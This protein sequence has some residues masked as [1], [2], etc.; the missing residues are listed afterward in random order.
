MGTVVSIG[1]EERRKILP[2]RSDVTVSKGIDFFDKVIGSEGSRFQLGS[3]TLQLPA[4]KEV[5]N[6]LDSPLAHDA[7]PGLLDYQAAIFYNSINFYNGIARLS[8][9]QRNSRPSDYALELIG[10]GR[11][12]W[13]QCAG[14]SMHDLDLGDVL[15]SRANIKASWTATSSTLNYIF[16][17]VLYGKPSG[18]VEP[19]D[20]DP[21]FS[22]EDFRPS[23]YFPAIVEAIGAATGYRIQGQ[24]LALPIFKDAV[25]LCTR[26]ARDIRQV[27]PPYCQVSL[28]RTSTKAFANGAALDFN[29]ASGC[30]YV[31]VTGVGT[32]ITANATMDLRITLNMSGT[33]I[34]E[35]LVYVNGLYDSIK[36][37]SANGTF[38][39]QTIIL[40][41]D[42]GDVITF[43]A[44]GGGAGGITV[45][46]AALYLERVFNPDSLVDKTISLST[47]LHPH[48]VRDYINAI[49]HEYGLLWIVDNKTK[50]ITVKPRFNFKLNGVLYRG[51]YD[52]IPTPQTISASEEISYQTDDYFGRHIELAYKQEGEYLFDILA[53]SNQQ[54]CPVGGVRMEIA[55][56]QGTGTSSTNPLFAY[57]PQL[58]YGRFTSLPAVLGDDYDGNSVDLPEEWTGEGPPMCGLLY[59]G[60]ATILYDEATGTP[61]QYDVPWISQQ[62]GLSPNTQPLEKPYQIGYN[63]TG[64]TPGLVSIFYRQYLACIRNPETARFQSKINVSVFDGFDFSGTYQARMGGGSIGQWIALLIGSYSPNIQ[65]GQVTMIKLR[66]VTEDV[67]NAIENYEGQ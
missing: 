66:P 46:F 23:V 54:D 21:A 58:R 15:V 35:I 53:S 9:G 16:A 55:G 30:D 28:L 13:E 67:I 29:T 32:P 14:L 6:I 17:P 3:N 10:N 59:R 12:F 34:D 26:A 43:L 65:Q 56:S 1:S 49:S 18:L 44:N 38:V 2:T 24:I 25:Y 39:T 33:T 62:A 48:S 63:D 52:T 22:D 60:N 64:D 37:E 40:A 7:K 8:A 61:N 19:E 47:A 36:F 4:T 20:V 5:D 41:V 11:D 45:T 51:H 50:R 27:L 31:D 42:N 57:L